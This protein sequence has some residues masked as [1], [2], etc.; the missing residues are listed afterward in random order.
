MPVWTVFVIIVVLVVAYY[1]STSYAKE[2]RR[3]SVGT[4]FEKIPGFHPNQVFLDAHGDSAIGID[5][6]GRRLAVVRKRTQPRNRVYSFAQVRSVELVD[7]GRTVATLPAG[8]ESPSAHAQAPLFGST[9]WKRP[10][11]VDIPSDPTPLSLLG[12]KVAFDDPASPGLFLRFYAGKPVD[13]RSLAADKALGQARACL[14]AFDLV[15]KK[16]ALTQTT[17]SA[18]P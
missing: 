18:Q 14:S 13:R 10:V 15:L 17:G 6:R 7:N 9:A 5:D 1:A 3:E 8:D 4:G 11:P 12:V 16:A 2:K